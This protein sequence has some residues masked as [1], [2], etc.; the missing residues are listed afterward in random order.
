MADL[1]SDVRKS[2]VPPAGQTIEEDPDLHDLV[3]DTLDP[4]AL[5]ASL[6]DVDQDAAGLTTGASRPE[7]TQ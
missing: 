2:G 5:D 3:H 1:A 4:E 7:Q 6:Y